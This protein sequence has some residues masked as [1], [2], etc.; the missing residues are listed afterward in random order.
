[1]KIVLAHY[2]GS[3]DIS[4]V[5]TWL[6][7]FCERLVKAGH[8]VVMHLHHFGDDPLQGSIMPSLRRLGIETHAVRRTGSLVVDSRQTLQFLNQV[9]PD[10]FL[11]Q[12]LHAH[13]VAAAHAGRQG[14]PWIFTMHSD[15]PDYWCVAEALTPE[16]HGGS[17]VCVS[18]FLAQQLRQRLP[19]TNPQ[20]IPYGITLPADQASFSDQPFRVVYSGRMVE[21][22]KCI[23]QVVH[24]LIHACRASNQIEAHLIGDGPDRTACEQLVHQAGL[25]GRIHFHGRIPPEQV[26][27]LLQRSQAILLMSDFEGLPVALLEAMAAGVVPVVRA[28][29]S[30]IPELVHHE[31]TGLLVGNDP[32]E[33]AAA[34]VRL[35]REPGLWQRCSTQSRALV[36][37]GYGAD[38]CF[39]RWLAV[40]EQQRGPARPTFPIRTAGL[41]RL[42]PHADPRFQSQYQPPPSRWSR[43]HPRRLL[44]RLRR[45]VARITMAS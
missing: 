11:P 9:Q 14:L 20:V 1:M 36:E 24:T 42:L 28:I 22:Q 15:D 26:Q 16:T 31:R 33:A 6:I 29:E 3:A 43:L 25:E 7:G 37:G 35:S 18:Q 41:R 8:E 34:L 4:G 32:A 17:S 27:P 10:L 19:A 39:E 23:Q 21:R 12:C 13:Y 2:S 45:G 40:M 5:T 38:Q 44:G 30:G